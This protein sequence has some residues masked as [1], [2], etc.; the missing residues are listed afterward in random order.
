MFFSFLDPE[1]GQN[2]SEFG[3]SSILQNN[4]STVIHTGYFL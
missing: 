3:F 4:I 1:Q 2:E